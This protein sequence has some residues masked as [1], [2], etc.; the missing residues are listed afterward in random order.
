MMTVVAVKQVSAVG[1]PVV[2][3]R[4]LAEQRLQ[5]RRERASCRDRLWRGACFAD[6]PTSCLRE[7]N[8]I[9]SDGATATVSWK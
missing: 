2:L 9:A 6:K 8:A 5:F 7:L 3:W 1:W 4:V